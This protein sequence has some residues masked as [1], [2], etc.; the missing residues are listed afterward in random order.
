MQAASG[1]RLPT[2]HE[3]DKEV[4]DKDY[5]DCQPADGS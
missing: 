4:L 1:Y 2:G 3:L 5:L